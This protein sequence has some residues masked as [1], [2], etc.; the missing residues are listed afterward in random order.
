MFVKR[1]NFFGLV[2]NEYDFFTIFIPIIV[3]LIISW[4]TVKDKEANKFYILISIFM[5]LT[6]LFGLYIHDHGTNHLLDNL[7][8]G[9]FMS[10]N[11]VLSVT[12]CVLYSIYTAKSFKNILIY[13]IMSYIV[14]YLLFNFC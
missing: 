13:G 2:E 11:L 14:F 9:M 12:G 5:G 10:I 1:K 7:I 3:G 4:L 8:P 6:I